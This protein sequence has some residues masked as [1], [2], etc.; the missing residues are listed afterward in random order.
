MVVGGEMTAGEKM[1]T[2]GF[3]KKRKEKEK[4]EREGEWR[5]KN[6]LKRICKGQK[7]RWVGGGGEKSKCIIYKLYIPLCAI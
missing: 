3:G 5:R 2:E 7:Y 6:G 4:W 1:K